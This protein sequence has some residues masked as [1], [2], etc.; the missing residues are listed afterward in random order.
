MEPHCLQHA[1][2]WSLDTCSTQ[3]SSV[4]RVQIHGALNRDI[5]LYQP[6]NRSSVFL[7]TTTYTRGALGGS[8]MECGVGGQPH[9][10]P[11]F[12]PRHRYP[13]SQ[14]ESGSCS[15]ASAPVSGLSAPACT[16]GVW[17]LLRAVSVAQKNKPSTMLSSNVQS[18]SPHGLHGLTVL[19]DETTEWL[20]NTCPEIQSGQAVD[21]KTSSK[22]EI[23]CML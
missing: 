18:T 20:L 17:P 6:H 21:R 10:T 22:E 4:H 9:K 13:P 12:H 1:V 8:S 16:N 15:T 11:R 3:R 19:A 23:V 5:H 2:P 7:A 14:E